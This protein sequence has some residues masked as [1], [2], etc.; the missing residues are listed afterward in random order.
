MERVLENQRYKNKNWMEKQYIEKDLSAEE[1]AT[2]V[3]CG[4]KTIYNWLRKLNIP[5]KRLPLNQDYK[6]GEWLYEQYIEKDLTIKEIAEIINCSLSTVNR[7]LR[8]LNIPYKMESCINPR[9]KDRDWLCD[10]Y[11]NQGKTIY[12]IADE[13]GVGDST[14]QRWIHILKVPV[15]Y[16]RGDREARFKY[17]DKKWL[18]RQYIVKQKHQYEI[19]DELEVSQSVICSWLR[20]HGIDTRTGGPL[21]NFF[22]ES[23]EINEFIDGSLL[24]DGS[25]QCRSTRAARYSLGQ[26]HREYCQWVGD[27]LTD[28]GVKQSGKIS[29]RLSSFGDYRPTIVYNYR[30]LDYGNFKKHY[31]RWYSGG[32]KQVPEDI[33]ITPISLRHWFIED[34]NFNQ[35]SWG[36]REITF[37]THCFSKQSIKYLVRKLA[38]KLDVFADWINIHNHYHSQIIHFA[39]PKV[40]KAFFNYMAPLPEPL[41]PIY[42]YKWP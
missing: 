21:T 20:K 41:E 22:E 8:E 27:Y 33:L 16:N 7:W 18:Q 23:K 26:K 24:G 12:E 9:Y 36:T 34:G 3:G 42:G 11:V 4:M 15:Q 38:N 25:L 17:R 28:F 35:R 37:A 19:A 29:S 40:V 2:L 10:Q 13:I 30:T 1:I 6:N 5:H 31:E 32:E 39:K 14:I